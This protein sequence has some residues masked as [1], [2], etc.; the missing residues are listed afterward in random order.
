MECAH[1]G[2]VLK[3]SAHTLNKLLIYECALDIIAIAL[4]NIKGPENKK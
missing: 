1:N 4:Q 3:E 2:Q